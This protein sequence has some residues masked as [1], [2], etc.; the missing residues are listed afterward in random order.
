MPWIHVL[1]DGQV[2][3]P[4]FYATETLINA[5]LGQGDS[6]IQK[7]TIPDIVEPGVWYDSVGDSFGVEPPSTET[8]PADSE[9]LRQ[10]LR[11][12]NAYNAYHTGVRRQGWTSLG[13]SASNDALLAT[14]RWVYTQVALGDLIARSEWI[15]ARTQVVRDAAIDRIVE[16]VGNNGYTWYS[17]MLDNM[18]SRDNWKATG[19]AGGSSLIYTDLLVG[20]GSN[21]GDLRTVDGTWNATT[22][23]IN[24]N[25]DPEEATLRT[26]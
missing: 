24:T 18:G 26:S 20:V 10:L 2:A 6:K 8:G 12:H 7:T 15:S 22:A 9:V 16:W 14:D 11:L 19:V 21:A 4:A 1:S 5:A 17:V 25:F 13:D 23:V 3:N